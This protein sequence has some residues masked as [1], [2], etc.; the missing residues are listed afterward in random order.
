ADHQKIARVSDR[1]AAYGMPG[2]TVDGNDVEAVHAAAE[3]AVSRARRGGGPTLL[4]CVTYRW[5]GHFEGDPQPY[6]TAEEVESWKLRDP[7]K[8]AESR[9]AEG[10]LA[11]AEAVQAIWSEI[12]IEV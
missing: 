9:L 2:E 12:R 11:D 5:R 4:E 8:L 10:G 6:R 1:A 7:L 3:R